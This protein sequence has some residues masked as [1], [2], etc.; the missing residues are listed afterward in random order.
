[1]QQVQ[2]IDV[3]WCSLSTRRPL[4]YWSAMAWTDSRKTSSFIVRR[5]APASYALKNLPPACSRCC[6]HCGAVAVQTSLTCKTREAHTL[7][8]HVRRCIEPGWRTAAH[9]LRWSCCCLQAHRGRR[10]GAAGV[11]KSTLH[12]SRSRAASDAPPCTDRMLM[13]T[14]GTNDRKLHE[15][16][17]QGPHTGAARPPFH[18][19]S[20]PPA[21]DCERHSGPGD[22]CVP[23]TTSYPQ[24]AR[25]T[26][27][28]TSSCFQ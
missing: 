6:H 5:S 10:R 7:F 28:A 2:R 19:P 3:S 12:R 9:R 17:I 18:P 14:A 21:A 23:S 4:G 25:H 26:S 16:C 11:T 1:M 8:Y 22:S 13:S 15:P 20:P 27:S 24:A